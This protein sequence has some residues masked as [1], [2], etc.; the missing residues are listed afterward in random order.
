MFHL[1][2]HLWPSRSKCPTH[3]Q[4]S[5]P[6]TPSLKVF[7]EKELHFLQGLSQAQSPVWN[8]RHNVTLGILVLLVANR[9][10]RCHLH[11]HTHT[12]PEKEKKKTFLRVFTAICEPSQPPPAC[13]HLPPPRQAFS[14]FFHL[15]PPKLGSPRAPASTGLGSLRLGWVPGGRRE[16]IGEVAKAEPSKFHL[17]LW[18]SCRV[19]GLALGW[20]L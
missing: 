9:F 8:C 1:P 3:S 20:Q 17:Q 14:S 6:R 18:S 5:F 15:Y 7:G 10:T 19:Q 4:T 13:H 11:T 12:T 16:S 2:L